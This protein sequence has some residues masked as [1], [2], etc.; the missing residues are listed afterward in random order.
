MLQLRR[1]CD[2]DGCTN[3]QVYYMVVMLL[4][5]PMLVITA[6]FGFMSSWSEYIV[7]AQ[8]LQEPKLYRLPLG[9]KQFQ[10]NMSTEWG[11][12]AAGALIVAI[13]IVVLFLITNKLLISGLTLGG[14]KE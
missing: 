5:T 4:P 14:V 2:I 10:Q 1:S 6:L 7:A 9:L 12:C 8:I 3:I 13:P 11:L